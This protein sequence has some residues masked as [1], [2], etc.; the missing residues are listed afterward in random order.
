LKSGKWAPHRV[1]VK[2]KL[3][4]IELL[5]PLELWFGPIQIG[6]VNRAYHTDL[7]WYGT[8]DLDVPW[9]RSTMIEALKAGD[10]AVVE[11]VLQS[12]KAYSLMSSRA[13]PTRDEL[14][15][16]GPQA[17]HMW[18]LKLICRY[19]WFATHEFPSLVESLAK[20]D[21]V[22]EQ[23]ACTQLSD[24]DGWDA[25]EL[26]DLL[27]LARRD[28]DPRVQKFATQALK[29]LGRSVQPNAR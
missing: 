14:A 10:Q 11:G 27:E 26:V 29:R 16:K 8:I 4:N 21:K 20:D 3:T 15:K 25:G 17:P 1:F 2:T 18:H 12:V 19:Y 22:P 5:E 9:A 28:A 6:V 23:L 24:K 7:N 13:L